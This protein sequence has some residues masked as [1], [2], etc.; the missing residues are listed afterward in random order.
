MTAD[1]PA[2]LAITG[3]TPARSMM[4]RKIFFA[5]PLR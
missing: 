3:Y 4:S 5:P 1:P 2:T